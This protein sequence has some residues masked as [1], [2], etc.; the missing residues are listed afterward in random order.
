MT[1]NSQKNTANRKVFP[2]R[3][4]KDYPKE[5]FC[6]LCHFKKKKKIVY[7]KMDCVTLHMTMGFPGGSDGKE[8]A[9][10]ARDVG[11]IPGSG[12]SPGEGNGYPLQY[13]CLDNSMDWGTWRAT[14]HRVAESDTTEILTQ[15]HTWLYYTKSYIIHTSWVVFLT[16]VYVNFMGTFFNTF[17]LKYSEKYGSPPLN[18]PFSILSL[19]IHEIWI[20]IFLLLLLILEYA[21]GLF[22]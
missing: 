11:S 8:S 22:C 21:F 20:M 1:L 3:K 15:Q 2:I 4:K 18:S 17:I 12:R 9:C 6:E 10:N 19:S 14:L 7:F 5:I 16:I 13:S